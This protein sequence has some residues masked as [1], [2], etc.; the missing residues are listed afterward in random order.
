MI[1]PQ[2][3]EIYN[4]H[5]EIIKNQD[6]ETPLDE[7][8]TQGTLIYQKDDT[9]TKLSKTLNQ[10]QARLEDIEYVAR[11]FEKYKEIEI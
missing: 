1:C 11:E 10:S 3:G 4:P 6:Q 9:K 2:C 8:S 5:Y 7:L